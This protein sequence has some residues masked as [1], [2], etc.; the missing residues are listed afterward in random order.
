[1]HKPVHKKKPA[2]KQPEAV[3]VQTPKAEIKPPAPV[4]EPDPVWPVNEKPVKAKVTWDSRGLTIVAENSSLAQILEDVT[5]LTGSAM[6]GF[7]EDRR[8]YGAYG[9]GNA[10]EV[11]SQLLQGSG[12]NVVMVG[13]LG[14][15]APRQ[16]QLALRTAASEK[17]GDKKA[18]Q[19]SNSDDNE[20]EE[21]PQQQSQPPMMPPNRVPPQPGQNL[22]NRFPG[23]PNPNQQPQN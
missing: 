11:L 7:E 4:P 13:D 1:M 6:D 18:G 3:S 23:A 8:I 2:K 9:P 5:T 20:D 21:P 17:A 16:I 10:R 12:Y 19:A 22:P 14:Q 15:G